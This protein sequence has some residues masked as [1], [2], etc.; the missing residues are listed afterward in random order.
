MRP[1][2]P[3]PAI[4]IIEPLGY[5]RVLKDLQAVEA[6]AA[7]RFRN[8]LEVQRAMPVCLPEIRFGDI[9]ESLGKT[10]ITRRPIQIRPA[11]GY[12]NLFTL[13][14]ADLLDWGV[15]WLVDQ[16]QSTSYSFLFAR[17]MG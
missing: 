1:V 7:F 12:F 13:Y 6:P 8:L 11:G 17:V 4:S 14:P 2:V 10:Y 5:L 15:I 9:M 16:R 3:S